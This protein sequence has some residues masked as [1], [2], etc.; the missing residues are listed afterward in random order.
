MKRNECG[1]E[2]DLLPY[3]AL[4]GLPRKL[5]SPA[6]TIAKATGRGESYFHFASPLY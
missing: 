4:F 2:E 6:H 3:Y 1:T 5:D